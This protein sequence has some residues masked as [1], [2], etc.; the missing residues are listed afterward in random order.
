MPVTNEKH[1]PSSPMNSDRCFR[2]EEG[3]CE[4]FYVDINIACSR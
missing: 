3:A 1:L 4:H 2:A